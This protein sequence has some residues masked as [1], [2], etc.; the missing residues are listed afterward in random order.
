M[1]ID[2]G[3]SLAWVRVCKESDDILISTQHGFATR[4]RADDT[5]LRPLSRTARGVTAMRLR[6]GDSMVDMDVIPAGCNETVVAITQHGIGKQ[7]SMAEFRPQRRGGMGKMA[8]RFREDG[9]RL[10]CLRTC[11]T[12]KEVVLSTA[13]GVVMRAKLSEILARGRYA[14]GVTLQK[15]DKG[16]KVVAVDMV[17]E[18]AA[19]N[20]AGVAGQD[21]ET[22]ED[23]E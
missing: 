8:I 20:N 3:D 15:L 17:Y 11:T 14:K 12:A 1:K 5:N 18:N 23:E 10:A 7:L 4:F 6:D 21:Q 19:S 2:P 22:H 13:S 16:D 9:D